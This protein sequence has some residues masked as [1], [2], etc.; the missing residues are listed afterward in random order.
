V[1]NFQLRVEDDKAVDTFASVRPRVRELEELQEENKAKLRLLAMSGF[2]LGLDSVVFTKMQA[3]CETIWDRSTEEGQH[4]HVDV[5][6]RFEEIIEKV[7]DTAIQEKTKMMM[8][9]AAQQVSPEVMAEMAERSGL[10][11]SSE[12]RTRRRG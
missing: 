1:T 11:S 12:R 5:E 4:K 2:Q 3:I 9:A 8:A 6:M 10:V 7:L